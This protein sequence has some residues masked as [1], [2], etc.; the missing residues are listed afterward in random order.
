MENLFE[1]FGIDGKLIIA[2][3]INFAI[4]ILVLQYFLYKPVLKMI[5]ER[6]AMIAKGVE[7][8]DKAQTLLL[9]AD[10]SATTLLQGAEKEAGEI[11]GT[12]RLEATDEKNRIA[13]E[14]QEQADRISKDA[15]TRSMEESAKM[16]RESEHEIARLA[17]LAAEKAMRAS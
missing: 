17:L 6:N 15:H 12:A 1:A 4:L 9:S 8:A 3:A 10:H 11:V 16:L 14:A 2:Q 7:D 13:K 5:T